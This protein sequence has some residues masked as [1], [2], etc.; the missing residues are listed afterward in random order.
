MKNRQKKYVW[1]LLW[2]FI[3]I[4]SLSFFA[5]EPAPL[6]AHQTRIVIEEGHNYQGD[7]LRSAA[8]IQK[9]DPR[10]DNLVTIS[11][12]ESHHSEILST[13]ASQIQA[14]L[15]AGRSRRCLYISNS[16]LLI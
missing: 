1:A 7:I 8:E 12:I 16:C 4:S 13:L 10:E 6:A 2:L 5:P 9:E 14:S 3:A 15:H 11:H